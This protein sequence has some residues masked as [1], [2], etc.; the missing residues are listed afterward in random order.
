MSAAAAG[1]TPWP[2]PAQ[3]APPRR[4]RRARRLLLAALAVYAAAIGAAV[5]VGLLAA[6]GIHFWADIVWHV[7]FP[8]L[9]G[10]HP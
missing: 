9:G 6:S 10:I 1:R 8:A 3:S 7:L 5:G 2:W 4:A